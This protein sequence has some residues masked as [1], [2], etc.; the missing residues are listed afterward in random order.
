[1]R[2]STL[3]KQAAWLQPFQNLVWEEYL[4]KTAVQM[5]A[6]REGSDKSLKAYQFN[7]NQNTLVFQVIAINK[8]MIYTDKCNVPCQR[9]LFYTNMSL[10]VVK[11]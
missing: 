9:N 3:L 7:F 1:M 4:A 2:A 10:L 6:T 5:M 8:G 11:S